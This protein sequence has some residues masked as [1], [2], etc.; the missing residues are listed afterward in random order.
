[1]SSDDCYDLQVTGLHACTHARFTSRTLSARITQ[2]KYTCSPLVSNRYEPPTFASLIISSASVARVAPPQC[3]CVEP[4]FTFDLFTTPA[5]GSC[6]FTNPGH[7][8]GSRTPTSLPPSGS[9][10][11][12]RE[13]EQ[14]YRRAEAPIEKTCN[15]GVRT[16]STALT[17]WKPTNVDRC[18]T[19]APEANPGRA[20]QPRSVVCSTN[21]HRNA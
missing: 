13:Y 19:R 21:M 12:Q 4:T 16:V 7:K 10:P 5:P 11:N 15:H 9:L 2:V 20:E 3:L 18:S 8:D 14:D 17:A 1:M 6:W